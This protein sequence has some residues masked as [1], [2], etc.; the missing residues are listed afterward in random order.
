MFLEYLKG[1]RKKKKKKP[2]EILFCHYEYIKHFCN[3]SFTKK[4]FLQPKLLTDV[5]TDAAI[6]VLLNLEGSY[7]PRRL[8]LFKDCNGFGLLI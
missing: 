5:S 4:R 1:N 2:R 3:K 7:L 6:N 8:V